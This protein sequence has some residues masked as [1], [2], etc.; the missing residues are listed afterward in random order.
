MNRV[1]IFFPDS[2]NHAM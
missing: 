1:I 2:P